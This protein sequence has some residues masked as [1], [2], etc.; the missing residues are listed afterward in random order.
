MGIVL[1]IY[2]VASGHV[3]GHAGRIAVDLAVHNPR[4]PAVYV[5]D[6]FLAVVVPSGRLPAAFVNAGH[7]AAG[8]PGVANNEGG[9]S[10]VPAQ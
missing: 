6:S 10:S 4:P 3:S 2:H 5:R 8:Q 9:P 1:F 7:G